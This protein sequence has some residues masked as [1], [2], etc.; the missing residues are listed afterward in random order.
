MVPLP[1]RIDDKVWVLVKERYQQGVHRE[2]CKG[3]SKF[4]N[5]ACLMRGYGIYLHNEIWYDIYQR[6][7]GKSKTESQELCVGED[8]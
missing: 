1:L 3:G 6:G 4:G 5:W 7:C 8:I 2:D